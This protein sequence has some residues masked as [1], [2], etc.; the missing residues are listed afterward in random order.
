[1]NLEPVVKHSVPVCTEARDLM[2][3]GKARL[4]EV[5]LVIY[6]D[7]F[8]IRVTLNAIVCFSIFHV[9]VRS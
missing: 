8:F 5:Q 2:E 4:A 3:A 7:S 9:H 1:M 6:S